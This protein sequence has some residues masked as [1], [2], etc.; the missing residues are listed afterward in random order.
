M[1]ELFFLAAL[2]FTTA[3]AAL[4]FPAVGAFPEAAGA[5]PDDAPEED[6]S[7]RVFESGA[8]PLILLLLEVLRLIGLQ[9][10]CR[11]SLIVS[12]LFGG[13]VKEAC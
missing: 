5:F 2:A 11:E 10:F 6:V 4:A 13:V 12:L 1:A 3:G 9:L 8:F 7:V